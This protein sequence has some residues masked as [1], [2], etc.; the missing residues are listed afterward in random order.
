VQAGSGLLR[1]EDYGRYREPALPAAPHCVTLRSGLRERLNF[2][3]SDCAISSLNISRVGISVH[4]ASRDGARPHARQCRASVASHSSRRAKSTVTTAHSGPEEPCIS[5]GF[6]V[7]PF[8]LGR[9]GLSPALAENSPFLTL[10]SPSRWTSRLSSA[11][12]GFC[13][14]LADQE[15]TFDLE[16]A[17]F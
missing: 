16:R 5:Q 10:S 1:E 8:G 4:R 17:I 6:G 2:T 12:G 15:F 14:F 7:L 9:C 3:Y 11:S 13:D